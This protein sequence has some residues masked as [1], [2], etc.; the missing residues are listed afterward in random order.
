MLCIKLHPPKIEK[1]PPSEPKLHPLTRFL[2]KLES[3]AKKDK[4]K[5]ASLRAM[6]S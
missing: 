3:F 5:K 4:H 6:S 1:A 2:S